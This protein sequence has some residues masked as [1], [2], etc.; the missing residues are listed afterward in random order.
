[1]ICNRQILHGS[2]PNCGYAKL[3]VNFG[4]HKKSSVLGT[5]GDQHSEAQVFDEEIISRRSDS[6]LAMQL[7][8]QKSHRI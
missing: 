8:H 5:K 7:R 2:F 1:M 3:N 4:F 6:L